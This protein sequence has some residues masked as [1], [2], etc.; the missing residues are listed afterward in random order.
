MGLQCF[1][2]G[3]NGALPGTGAADR[4]Q[5]VEAFGCGSVKLVIVR[6]DD[7][8]ND[9]NLAVPRENCKDRPDQGFAED[10]QVLLGQRPARAQ[11]TPGGYDHGCDSHCFVLL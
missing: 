2:A 5:Q 11:S 4:R 1:E 3:S 10:M 9:G 8:L 7:R 6:V